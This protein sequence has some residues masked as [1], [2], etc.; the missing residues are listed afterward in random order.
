MSDLIQQLRDILGDD[1]VLTG[2]DVRLRDNGWGHPEPC[3]AAAILRPRSTAEVAA[4]MAR[5]HAEGRAVVAQGGLTGLV[6][7]AI[8]A[9]GEIALSFERMNEI[10]EVDT[11]TRTITAQAGVPLQAIQER[12][13]AEGF[14]FPLD[15]GA[16]GSCT[17]GGNVATN[18]GGNRVIR[19]GMTRDL[20]LGV[21]AVLA[22]GTIVGSLNKVL[23]N[24]A[25]YDLKHLFIGSEG[26][27]GIVTRVV[28]RLRP[29]PRSHNAALV[30]VDDFARVTRLLAAAE[31]GL[32]ADL[33]AF[34]VMWEDFYRLTTTPP[35]KTAPPIP[36]GHAHYV[37]IEAL[38]SA[39][40]SDADHFEAVLAEA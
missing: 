33:S 39:P 30:A 19:Y 2:D 16:R 9:P 3:E 13:D 18:A 5:C 20:V 21:E 12:A 36:H 11:A 6:G 4:L 22:D 15:L 32:G 17:I 7:A 1:G 34:E 31:S 26:T 24:N 10:E 40:E 25:G 27:L 29:R 38:G 28:L 35:A 23:K 8:P 14:L 37:L